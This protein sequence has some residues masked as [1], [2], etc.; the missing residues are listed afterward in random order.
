MMKS[1]KS[2]AQT[3][4]LMNQILEERFNDLDK[5]ELLCKQLLEISDTTNDTYG[6]AFANLYIFDSLF[7][8]GK[9]EDAYFYLIR[10]RSLCEQHNYKDLLMVF[11]NLAG[12][13]YQNLF[14]EHSSLQHHLLAL[15]LAQKS[16][17]IVISSKAYNNLG[18]C[19]R[20]RCDNPAALEYFNAAYET[21]KD[22]LNDEV[23]GATITFLCNAAEVY[24]AM[25]MIEESKQKIQT[26]QTLFTDSRYS[27]L[28]IKSVW[29]GHYAVS[30]NREKSIQLAKEL[31]AEG[32]SEFEHIQFV[33]SVYYEVYDH[34]ISIDCKEMAYRYLTLVASCSSY[35]NI[36]RYYNYITQKIKYYE[37]YCTPT[38]CEE[39]YKEFYDVSLKLNKVDNALRIENVLSKINLTKAMYDLKT[40]RK[41]NKQLENASHIDEL[42]QLYNRRYISKLITKVQ[43]GSQAMT[44][45][46]VM[47]DVD[48]FKEYNDYY[49]HFKGDEALQCVAS[50]LKKNKK[51]DIYASRYGGDEF[52]VL[53][54]NYTKAQIIRYI[55]NVQKELMLQNVPHEKSNCS[56]VLTLS[57][58]FSNHLVDDNSMMNHLLECADKALY[59]AKEDGR[60]C[61]R[62][63]SATPLKI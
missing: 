22:H 18:I 62:Y 3:S 39:V 28:Q 50:I 61:Y 48:Y 44:L 59:Q 16:N 40:I 17:N 32:L 5:L 14:D 49:G 20:R 24:Q 53:F 38:E 8:R 26:A 56:S 54:V 15:D 27:Y 19:F 9:Y 30:G 1:I 46:Y 42:T 57:I 60:N 35:K 25:H 51:D 4:S 36:G 41:E 31:L 21:I 58:G 11:H 12:S 55:E 63:S 43:I 45:G 6:I 33:E 7:A 23:R 34:M 2:S 47:L 37:R 29:C 52:L 10:T 13:Y